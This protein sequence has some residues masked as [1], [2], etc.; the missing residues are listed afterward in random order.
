MDASL[1][2]DTFL[3][4]MN[5]PKNSSKSGLKIK[6]TMVLSV[7]IVLLFLFVNVNANTMPQMVFSPLMTI[8]AEDRRR[9]RALGDVMVLCVS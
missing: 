7:L 4:I 6:N 5:M 1:R 3:V 2:A 8:F 9:I